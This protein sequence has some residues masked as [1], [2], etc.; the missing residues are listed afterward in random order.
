MGAGSNVG[1][2]DFSG[3]PVLLLAL[4]SVVAFQ[5]ELIAFTASP[6]SICFCGKCKQAI[7]TEGNITNEH[8]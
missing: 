6:E 7:E 3:S 5:A 2:S 8:S 1:E 4:R